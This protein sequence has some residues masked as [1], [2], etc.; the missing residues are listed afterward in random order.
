MG[1][2]EE[3]VIVIGGALMLEGDRA[4]TRCWGVDVAVT[5]AKDFP[6]SAFVAVVA[7]TGTG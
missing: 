5:D 6:L 4:S 7:A 2:R 3:V 1:G